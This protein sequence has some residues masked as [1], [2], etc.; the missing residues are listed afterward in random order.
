MHLTTQTA[1]IRRIGVE[2]ADIRSIEL[3]GADGK[4]LQPFEAALMSIYISANR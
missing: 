2:A 3:V 1:L 4:P